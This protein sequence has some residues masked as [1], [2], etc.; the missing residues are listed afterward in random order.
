MSVTSEGSRLV[1]PLHFGDPAAP[2]YG[3]Y[4]AAAGERADTAVVLCPPA[5]QQY[6]VTHWALRRLATLL[7]ESGVPVLRFDY[8]GT[9]DSA[10]ASDAGTLATWVANV[11]EARE[12]VRALSGAA[13]TALVGYGMGAVVAWRASRDAEDRPRDLVLWDPVVHGARHLDELAAAEAAFAVR[14]LHF[15]DYGDPPHDL[16]GH[17]FPPVQRAETA[18]VNLLEEP[19]PQATRLHLYVS[20]ESPETEALAERLRAGVRRFTH[21]HVPDAPAPHDGE[22]LLPGR[23]LRTIAQALARAAA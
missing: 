16:G 20:A 11:G 8:F 13:R 21:A 1:R 14:L 3:V 5:P 9:G 19:L 23:M 4:H 10:G 6:M 22:Q 12:A 17:P 2:L 7:A 18:G 15:P